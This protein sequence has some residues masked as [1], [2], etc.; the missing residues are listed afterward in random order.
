MVEQ[1]PELVEHVRDGR[2]EQFG[3]AGEVVEKN[4]PK[5]TSAASVI[6]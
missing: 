2:L 1:R 4:Q 3:L 6:S 5:P